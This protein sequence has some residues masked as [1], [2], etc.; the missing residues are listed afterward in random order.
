MQLPSNLVAVYLEEFKRTL[1]WA[2]LPT[3]DPEFGQL[4]ANKQSRQSR[5][6]A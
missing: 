5:K 1:A 2:I 3:T 4:A 6:T